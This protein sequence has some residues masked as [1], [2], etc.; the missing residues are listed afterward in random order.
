MRAMVAVLQVYRTNHVR[1][2]T[3]RIVRNGGGWNP[4]R[5]CA[6]TSLFEIEETA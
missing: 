1:R 6:M 2:C 5:R 3:G 4:D